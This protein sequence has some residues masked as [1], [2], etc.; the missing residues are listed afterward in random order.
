MVIGQ[1]RAGKTSL[2]KSLL[3]EPFDPEEPS[4]V[5][6]DVKCKVEVGLVKNWQ[7]LDDDLLGA[8]KVPSDI[9]KSVVKQLEENERA[10]P[11][12]FQRSVDRTLD[13]EEV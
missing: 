9:A 12:G 6:V 1:D 3:G 10:S 11:S 13:T 7:R 4:T 8:F 2:K 5:G